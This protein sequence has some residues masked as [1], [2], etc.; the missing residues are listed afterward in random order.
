MYP[1]EPTRDGVSTVTHA[2]VLL[3]THHAKR[4]ANGCNFSK[5]PYPPLDN[6]Y[7]RRTAL[8][9]LGRFS[10]LRPRPPRSL[11]GAGRGGAAAAA[12]PH[13]GGAH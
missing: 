9:L 1:R 8:G 12:M 3:C 10:V 7:V 6:R 2:T 11:P 4:L 13:M 5:S